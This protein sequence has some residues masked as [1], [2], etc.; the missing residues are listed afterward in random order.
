MKV[1]R[2]EVMPVCVSQPQEAARSKAAGSLQKELMLVLQ[3]LSMLKT[4]SSQVRL[5]MCLL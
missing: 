3:E 5:Y 2:S 4:L 1:A